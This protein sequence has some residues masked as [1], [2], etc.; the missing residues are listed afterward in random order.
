MHFRQLNGGGNSGRLFAQQRRITIT[1]CW[2]I[3][4]IV[5]SPPTCQIH[6]KLQSRAG[7]V[8]SSERWLTVVSASVIG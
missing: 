8:P 6:K 5:S 3:C 7:Q 4:L 2:T 1:M